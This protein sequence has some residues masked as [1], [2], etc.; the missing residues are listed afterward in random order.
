MEQTG[1]TLRFDPSRCER[2]GVYGQDQRSS[3]RDSRTLLW[4]QVVEE[5]CAFV[6]M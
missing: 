1:L 6:I 2:R 5:W 3:P 4:E